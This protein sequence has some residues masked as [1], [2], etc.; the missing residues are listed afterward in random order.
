L[1]PSIVLLENVPAVQH[2]SGDVVGKAT[3][4]LGDLGYR[5]ASGVLNLSAVG[6]PQTRRRHFVVGLLGDR[7]DPAT[8]LDG[9]G[10]CANHPPRSVRWAIED[11]RGNTTKDGFDASSHASADNETRMRWLFE[12]DAFD[13]P[14]EHRP[15]CH[16]GDHTYTSMYGRLCW[17]LPAQTITTGF[18]SMGQG[19]YVHPSERRTITPHEAARLQTFPDFFDFGSDGRGALSTMIGNA[20]PPLVSLRLVLRVLPVL[21]HDDHHIGQT[22]TERQ[23]AEGHSLVAT[24]S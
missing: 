20:V 15:V 1:R 5:V 7:V 18:G 14:N 17:D 12:N 9:T 19:R 21:G 6:V 22:V 10:L 3:E 2:D 13:L 23:D 8:V 16:Q 24:G 11:L 4:S